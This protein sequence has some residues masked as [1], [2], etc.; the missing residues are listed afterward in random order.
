MRDMGQLLEGWQLDVGDVRERMYRAPTPGERERW[1]ALWLLAQGWT[2][3]AVAE[4]L[5]RDS[6]TI[7]TWVTALSDGG[8]AALGFEQSGGFPRPRRGPAG[9]TEDCGPGAARRGR[10]RLGELELE[11]YAEICPRTLRA[12]A[13]P[14]QLF[15]LP[16]PLGVCPETA[17]ETFP[18]GR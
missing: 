14:Q 2:A 1:H 13:E 10:H 17:Q 18:E 6:H 5:E 8:P 7:G 9:P 16:P 12:L 4:G 3:L 15:E 11:S